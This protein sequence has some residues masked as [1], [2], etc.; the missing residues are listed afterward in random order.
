MLGHETHVPKAGD[1]LT[2]YMGEDPVILVRQKDR[3]LKVFL[4]QCPHRGMR[5]CRTDGGNAKSFT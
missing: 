4:N 3:S 5:I 1:F 2:A